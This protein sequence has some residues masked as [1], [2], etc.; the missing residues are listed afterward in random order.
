MWTRAGCVVVLVYMYTSLRRA[1]ST[2]HIH[3]PPIKAHTIHTRPQIFPY[4]ESKAGGADDQQRVELGERRAEERVVLPE[5]AARRPQE[6][7]LH[8][9]VVVLVFRGV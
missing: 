8:L 7:G 9:V 5:G 3:S 6:A 2:I 4:L 1:L